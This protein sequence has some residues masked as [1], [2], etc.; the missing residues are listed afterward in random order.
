MYSKDVYDK[1]REWSEKTLFLLRGLLPRMAPVA[2]NSRWTTDQRKTLAHLLTATARS[3]EGALLLTAYAQLWDAEILVRSV[4]EGTLKF[5]YLLQA[6]ASFEVR[7]REYSHDLFRIGLLKDHAKYAELLTVLPDSNDEMWR[8]FKERLL[9]DAQREEI[10]TDYPKSVRGALENR[11]G[12]TG[13]I[14]TL[15]RSGDPLFKGITG[16]A[17]GYAM[18]S[19]IVH[20]DSL[21]TSVPLEIDKRSSER[22]DTLLLAHGTRLMSDVLSC[23]HIRLA[24]A[25]RFIGHD[26]GPVEQTQKSIDE[27]RASFGSVYEEWMS[28]EYGASSGSQSEART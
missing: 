3:S 15:A 8:P 23:F 18:A 2:Q 17:S 19:H 28:A 22:R 1:L 20:A 5:A 10:A 4:T 9:P 25:Y 14:G 6:P 27:L 7:H 21:G 26:P 12:F 11:W 24:V 13:L 16:L